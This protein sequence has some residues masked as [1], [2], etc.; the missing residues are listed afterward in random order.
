MTEPNFN[1]GLNTA[2]AAGPAGLP[3]RAR[4]YASVISLLFGRLEL[5]GTLKTARRGARH[6]SLGVRLTDPT[7]LDRAI[8]LA[9]PLAL[10]T[11]TQAV[12]AGRE[13][14]LVIYQFQLAQGYWEYYTRA[15]LPSAEAIGLAEQHRPVVFRLDPPHALVA[16]TTGSGK[17]EAIKSMLISLMLAYRPDEL[18]LILIDPHR[19]FDD[20]ANAAHLIIPVACEAEEIS[21]AL[22]L[23]NQELA[24]RKAENIKGGKLWVVV[25]DEASDPATL[26]DKRGGFN[27]E[28][29]VIIKQISSQARKY[30]IHLVL[31]TQKPSHTDLPGIFDLLNN[32]L[33]GQVADA[34]L[35]AA[36]T[37][38]SGL[39]A[40]KLTG[41]GDF[42]HVTGPDYKRFQ[43]AVAGRADFEKLERALP[44]PIQVVTPDLI[45]FPLEPD[46][47]PAGG[48]P[49]LKVD[50]VIAA[51]YFWRNPASISIPMAK[52]LFGLSRDGHGLHRDFVQEFIIEVNR[53]RTERLAA[54]G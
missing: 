25:I 39:Q 50:P 48:R 26:G 22:R 45:E 30:C 18:G 13:G 24:R 34:R 11:A 5:T 37:G 16:G 32:R 46:P 36:L 1:Q 49:P 14:G 17:T 6:L 15:D 23:A 12:I 28:N 4:R 44:S 7:R 31:G 53:L 3:N 33:V 21:Q 27:D 20:F 43:V 10:H 38:Q 8:G 51:N 42:L 9:E 41:K 35:S 19:V 40:H 52:E 47:K 54:K 29:L 2:Q